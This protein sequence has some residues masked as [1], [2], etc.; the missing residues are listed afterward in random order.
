MREALTLV[1]PI[2]F[3]ITEPVKINLLTPQGATYKNK[4]T[5]FKENVTVIEFKDI[6]KVSKERKVQL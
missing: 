3:A 1:E 2:E 6:S 4:F 5:G